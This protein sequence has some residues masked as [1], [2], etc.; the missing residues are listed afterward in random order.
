MDK[1]LGCYHRK[2]FAASVVLSLT[3]FAF[4]LF[5]SFRLLHSDTVTRFSRQASAIVT[6]VFWTD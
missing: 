2:K 1:K 3:L 5:D 4:P 6:A